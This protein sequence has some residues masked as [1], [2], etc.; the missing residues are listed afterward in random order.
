MNDVIFFDRLDGNSIDA[1]GAQ[2]YQYRMY[3]K[4]H[5]RVSMVG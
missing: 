4:V 2:P 1:A 5:F 3:H